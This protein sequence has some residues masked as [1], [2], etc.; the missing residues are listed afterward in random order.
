MK[1]AKKITVHL[2][3]DLMEKAQKYTGKGITETIRIG[4]QLVAASEA[5]EKLRLL[6]GKV[7]FSLNLKDLRKDRE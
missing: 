6:R 3:E 5:Y 1:A 2:P 4:L 7:S